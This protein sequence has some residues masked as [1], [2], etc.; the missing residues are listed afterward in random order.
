MF[1]VR[2]RSNQCGLHAIQNMFKSSAITNDDMSSACND[3]HKQ[4]G[5]ALFNHES[6]GGDWSVS[7]VLAAIVRKG[8]TVEPAV[9][10]KNERTWIGSDI[11][12]LLSDK[13]FRGMII[14]QPLSRHFTCVRPEN[15]NGQRS[16]YYVD[17][18]SEGPIRISP[19][20]A[21]RRCLARAYS[22][23]PYV[24]KGPEME[25]VAPIP[26]PALPSPMEREQKR[27]QRPPDDFMKAWYATSTTKQPQ[28]QPQVLSSPP[29]SPSSE[30]VDIDK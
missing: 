30:S 7:A 12:E 22:W 13:D 23:E 3:I 24:V 19:K 11:S 14:H 28:K 4:T 8:Y 10:T 2:Q 18:Q 6:F 16:L 1:F 21:M 26:L 9:F 29:H 25:Y 27:A 15:V 5:D 17:S 20:L